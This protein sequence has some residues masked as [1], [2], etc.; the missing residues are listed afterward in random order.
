MH[1][2]VLPTTNNPEHISIHKF[3]SVFILQ[4]FCHIMSTII[5]T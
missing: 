4:G 3:T 1:N 5:L 2:A